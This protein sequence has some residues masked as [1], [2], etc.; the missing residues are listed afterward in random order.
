MKFRDRVDA[1]DMLA[2]RLAKAG[3]GRNDAVIVGIPR[4]GVILADIV[5]GRLMAD[6]DVVIPR[7]MGA[8][9]NDELA[10]GAVMEDGT[11]YI[12]QYIVNA[13]RITQD[14]IEAEKVRQAEEVRRRSSLYRKQGV[15]YKVKGRNAILVD[16]GVATGATVMASARW[17][18][19][20]EPASLTIAVPV[21]PYQTVAMLEQEADSVVVIMA[22]R[23]FGSVGQFYET[24]DPVSDEQVMQIMRARNLL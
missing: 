9:D 2:D 5:A 8:P 24:F 3:A 20:Q 4:G 12:N 10:I 11:Y 21:A 18:R 14:Y 19:R 7:K 17:L 13:L 1:G 23:D 15:P 22:P 6:F 16:D